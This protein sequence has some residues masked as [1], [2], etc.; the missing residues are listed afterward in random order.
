MFHLG[1]HFGF[2]AVFGPLDLIDNTTVTVVF[3]PVVDGT[4]L[5]LQ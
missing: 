1:P 4:F 5:I 3:S 2:G